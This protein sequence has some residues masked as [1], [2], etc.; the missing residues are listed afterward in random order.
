MASGIEIKVNL[1]S[2]NLWIGILQRARLLD[3]DRHCGHP[4]A[5]PEGAVVIW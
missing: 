2:I 3:N 5:I 1:Q 4:I